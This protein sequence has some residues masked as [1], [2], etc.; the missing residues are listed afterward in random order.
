MKFFGA[1]AS[2]GLMVAGASAA[3]A[4]P[5]LTGVGIGS[6]KAVV[7]GSADPNNLSGASLLIRMCPRNPWLQPWGGKGVA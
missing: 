4:L 2:V 6:D 5:G 7:S 1:V 3:V